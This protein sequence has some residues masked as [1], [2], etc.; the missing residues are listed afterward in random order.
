MQWNPKSL[1]PVANAAAWRKAMKMT[2]DGIFECL[3]TVQ[4]ILLP[5]DCHYDDYG[6]W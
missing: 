4:C 5:D 3:S 1:G 6:V 2:L